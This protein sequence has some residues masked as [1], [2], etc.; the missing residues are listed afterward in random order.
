MIFPIKMPK[1]F[2]Q[3]LPNHCTAEILTNYFLKFVDSVKVKRSKNKGKKIK[4]SAVIEFCS[5]N[6]LNK[7]INM[8]HY[9]LGEKLRIVPYRGDT[10]LKVS[11]RNNFL[12]KKEKSQVGQNKKMD[13]QP[14]Y[15]KKKTVLNSTGNKEIDLANYTKPFSKPGHKRKEL[16]GSDRPQRLEYH[17][18]GESSSV[19][20]KEKEKDPESPQKPIQQRKDSYHVSEKKSSPLPQSMLEHLGRHNAIPQETEKLKLQKEPVSANLIRV[21]PTP[22]EDEPQMNLGI[23]PF[24]SNLTELRLFSSRHLPT[25]L[26]NQIFSF[27]EN[28]GLARNHLSSITKR[29]DFICARRHVASNLRF[30][31]QSKKN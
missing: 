11:Q 31:F 23:L 3:S 5:L 29:S 18:N 22:Q 27:R 10:K 16:K 14:L 19:F 9:V 26:S 1:I 28:K 12:T 30:N 17:Y 7:I 13:D 15:F 24:V 4:M 25:G 8:D 6:D 21:A 2:V 20:I